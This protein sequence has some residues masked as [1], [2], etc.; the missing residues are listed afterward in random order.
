M[1]GEIKSSKAVIPLMRVL[2]QCDNF[3]LKTA[4]AW[5]LCNI[6]DDRGT[7]AVKLEVKFSDCDK[8]RLVCAW[9]YEH[10][11]KQGSFIFRDIDPAVLAEVKEP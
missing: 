4:A 9:Y 1:L 7:Y 10:K 11:V 3:K 2:K 5:A 8:T 6:G